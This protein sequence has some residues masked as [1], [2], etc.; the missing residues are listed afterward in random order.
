M[1]SRVAVLPASSWCYGSD[2]G[3]DG[4]LLA[5]IQYMNW[6]DGFCLWP[7]LPGGLPFCLPVYFYAECAGRAV[8]SASSWCYCETD[9][10]VLP[11]K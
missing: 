6:S 10:I 2:F 5:R 9:F 8:A 7:L 4:V 3:T 11:H 1:V